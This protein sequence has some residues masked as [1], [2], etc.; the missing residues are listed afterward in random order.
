MHTKTSPVCRPLQIETFRNFRRFLRQRIRDNCLFMLRFLHKS[1]F[2]KRDLKSGAPQGA[3]GFDPVPGIISIVENANG[4]LTRS[5]GALT[6]V[7]DERGCAFHRQPIVITE[8]A[9]AFSALNLQRRRGDN[10]RVN[11]VHS[12]SGKTF[13][14]TL[15]RHRP[16]TGANPFR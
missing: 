16:R 4:A 8:P 14:Q 11:N 1:R 10:T 5:S 7:G 2:T 6:G 3:Y 9:C 13:N 15:S 12:T